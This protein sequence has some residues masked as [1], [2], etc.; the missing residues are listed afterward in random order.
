[1]PPPAFQLGLD[2]A[3]ARL[4]GKGGPKIAETLTA[5]AKKYEEEKKVAE[6]I[7]AEKAKAKAQAEKDAKAKEAKGK[8]K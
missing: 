3:L 1:M 8:K 2:D 4:D 6:K 7:A 5:L